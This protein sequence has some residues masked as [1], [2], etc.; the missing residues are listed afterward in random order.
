MPA[1]SAFPWWIILVLLL[2]ILVVIG[3]CY[4]WNKKKQENGKL[5]GQRADSV[6]ERCSKNLLL[7]NDL[8]VGNVNEIKDKDGELVAE[9]DEEE[10]QVRFRGKNRFTVKP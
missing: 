1:K 2:I 8:E 9:Q 7:E 10:N 5:T 6:F 3:A 4:F